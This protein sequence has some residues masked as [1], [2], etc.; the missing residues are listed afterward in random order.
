MMRG[1]HGGSE[2]PEGGWHLEKEPLQLLQDVD[3]QWSLTHLM[4]DCYLTLLMVRPLCTG[5]HHF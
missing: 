2:G 3:T 1:I 5:V 4:I